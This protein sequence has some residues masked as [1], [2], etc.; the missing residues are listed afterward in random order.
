MAHRTDRSGLRP[1][2]PPYLLTSVLFLA[3][4]SVVP[5]ALEA[6][7]LIQIPLRWCAVDGSPAVTDPSSAPPNPYSGNPEPDTD[8]VLW[9][10]HERASDNIWIP[11]ADIT[12]RSG[13]TAAIRDSANFPIIPDPCPPTT[14]NLCQSGP[15]L[16][17]SCTPDG[18]G[19]DPAVCGA[20]VSCATQGCPGTCSTG[21]AGD[22]GD[23]AGTG[24]FCQSG[25][26]QGA[27]CNPD[28]ANQDPANCGA[29]VTCNRDLT[30]YNLVWDACTTAWEDLADTWDTPLLGPVAVNIGV[31]RNPDGARDGLKGRA[32]GSTIDGNLCAIPPTGVTTAT[33]G[34]IVVIDNQNF[35]AADIPFETTN[36][37]MVAH[38]L[39]HDL[40][41]WHGDGIDN[42]PDGVFDQACDNDEDTC[43]NPTTFMSSTACGNLSTNMTPTQRQT[44]RPIAAVY[45]GA[46]QDPPGVLIPSPAV[47]DQHSDRP[48]DVSDPGIDIGSLA[49]VENVDTETTTFIHT[50]VGVIPLLPDP[51]RQY[52]VLADLDG[53][54]STGGAPENLGLAT[55][56]EG[57]ELVTRV[58]VGVDAL[59]EFRAVT[60]TVWRFRDGELHECTRESDPQCAGIRANVF[61]VLG[62]D[63][64][65]ER[66]EE[67]GPDVVANAVTILLPTAVRG[68]LGRRPRIQAFSEQLSETIPEGRLQLDRLPDQPTDGGRVFRPQPP[69]F[70]V[71]GVTPDPVR[72]GDLATV[73]AIG[74]HEN[75]TAKVFLGDR[76]VAEGPIDSDGSV[77][78]AFQVPFDARLGHRLVTVGVMG[79]ALSADCFANVQGIPLPAPRF[80]YAA[81]LVCGDQPDPKSHRLARGTYATTVNIRNPGPSRATFFKHL[82]LTH[83]PGGQRPGR[84]TSPLRDTL[85]QD[86]A[87]AVDCDDIRDRVFAGKLPGK[88][89]EGFV[90]VRSPVSL[91]VVAVYTTTTLDAKKKAKDQGGIDVERVH[92]REIDP[93]FPG[94]PDLI[95]QDIDLSSLKVSCPQGPGSCTTEVTATIANV[96]AGD[97][98]A[99]TTQVVLDPAQS[100][101][102]LRPSPGGL[103][104][105][106]SENLDSTSAA[107]GSCFDPD[108]SVCV[109]VD[110]N[111]HVIEANEANNELC[112]TLFG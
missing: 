45:T 110:N 30:E 38:E 12:F 107:G 82:A 48:L 101:V 11:G 18:L 89:V 92:E 10:R 100:V 3:L 35:V 111:N 7:D 77:E 85:R 6:G 102:L 86:Q 105:G 69:V 112:K 60:P 21:C 63:D 39:G 19:Q 13:L 16:G 68:P 24:T 67:R 90:V 42:E 108:C 65:N 17:L 50:L 15:S 46:N 27:N 34:A 32:T 81:K 59:G 80:E 74:L 79:T 55:E 23:I 29:G 109:R 41:L 51:V 44:A 94:L 14:T 36:E 22:L 96:G 53:N 2:R 62:G 103:A 5:T 4:L 43:A 58:L 64:S 88:T 8:N 1:H 25:A 54:P 95:V 93:L 99:F 73:E 72:P 76:M 66:V 47:G 71:C 75:E 33:G 20:G 106:T 84:V 52:V 9:R 56:F 31:F 70:P 61:N 87:L 37:R 97:A 98:G 91:D 78:L 83:P 40:F 104:A 28:N 57:A 49:M 26:N